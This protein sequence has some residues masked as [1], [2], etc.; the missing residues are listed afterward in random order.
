ML[1]SQQSDKK[2]VSRRDFLRVASGLAG[3]GLLTACGGNTAAPAAPTTAPAAAEPTKAPDAAAPTPE[4]TVAVAEIGS[5]SKQTVFWHG[6]GG[7]DGKTMAEMLNQYA[8]AKG[9]TA[10]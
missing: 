3:V 2:V 5:G 9:D 6:L 8:K 10:V 1:M 7:A 4:P